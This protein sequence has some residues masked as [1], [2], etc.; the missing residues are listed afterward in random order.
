MEI[1][2]VENLI[3][4]KPKCINTCNRRQAEAVAQQSLREA[5]ELEKKLEEEKKRQREEQKR[6]IEA[7]QVSC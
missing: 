5:K 3:Q 4:W 7:A 1:V 2:S 6:K